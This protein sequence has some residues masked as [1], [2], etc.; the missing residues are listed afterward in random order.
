MVKIQD[1]ISLKGE[2][3]ITI[4]DFRRGPGEVLRQVEMGKT[5][6]ISRQG[7]VVAVISRPEPTAF[8]LGAAVRE[9]E[10]VQR[11]APVMEKQSQPP[12]VETRTFSDPVLTIPP[13]AN[14]TDQ[15]LPHW[16]KKP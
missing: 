11:H 13:P 1:Q 3:T 8:E 12:S 15:P 5:F 7:K 4:T 6:K 2:E 16:A 10:R 9:L 14:L